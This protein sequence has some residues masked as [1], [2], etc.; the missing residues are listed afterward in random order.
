MRKDCKGRKI[1]GAPLCELH[2][3]AKYWSFHRTHPKGGFW[4]CGRCEYQRKVGILPKLQRTP[5]KVYERN[6]E[7]KL[8]WGTSSRSYIKEGLITIYGYYYARGRLSECPME[9]NDQR[10][11]L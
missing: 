11:I 6:P 2:G 7:G 10:E 9:E 5:R 8:E 4:R 3:I 1:P